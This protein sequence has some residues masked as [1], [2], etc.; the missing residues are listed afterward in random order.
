MRKGLKSDDLEGVGSMPMEQG[1]LN[2]NLTIPNVHAFIN[3]LGH[4]QNII[5][6]YNARHSFPNSV[7]IQGIMGTEKRTDEQQVFVDIAKELFM[8]EA[9]DPRGLNLPLNQVDKNGKGGT[10]NNGN[11][12][13]LFFSPENREKVLDLFKTDTDKERED[14]NTFLTQTNVILRVMS[15]NKKVL[16]TEFCEFCVEAYRFRLK[17]FPWMEINK[18][19]HGLYHAGKMIE[20][21]DGF[22]LFQKNEGP[23]ESLHRVLREMARSGT[24]SMNLF[25]FLTDIVTKVY[26]KWSPVIRSQR[27]K[28]QTKKPRESF[29]YYDDFLVASFIDE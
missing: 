18:S 20:K 11:M 16:V 27:P 26:L 7:P 14:I 5:W 12:A 2:S 23:L 25:L 15:T 9:N 28:S 13:K 10:R 24:R 29:E 8:D 1:G 4:C 6:L 21:N 19:M 17:L 3:S 22:G